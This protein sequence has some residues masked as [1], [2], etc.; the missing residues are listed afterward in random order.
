[1]APSVLSPTPANVP[2]LFSPGPRR[3]SSFAD[4]DTLSN[5]GMSH[6]FSLGRLS[7]KRMTSRTTNI[8]SVVE[9]LKRRNGDELGSSASSQFINGVSYASLLDW[10][11]GQRMSLLPPEGSPYDK[12][13]AWAQ[14]F[15][16]RIH[17][18]DLAIEPFAGDSFLAAE[19][20]YGYCNMLLELG[21][22]NAQALI[23]SF[24]FFY[25]TSMT[26]A[27]LLERAELF[28][29]TQEI[30]DQLVLAL[31]D[32]VTLVASVSSHFHKA[33][34]EM[35]RKRIHIDIYR[36]FPSQIQTFRQRC[37]KIAIAMWRHQL[38]R[39]NVDGDRVS[40]VQSIRSWLT[41]DD[42]VLNNIAESVSHLA[43]ERE[44]L[45]CLWMSSY[46]GRF[47]KSNL[48]ALSLA[49]KPGSGRT[50]LASVIVDHLQHPIGG[51]SYNALFIPINA[52][53]PA[54]TSARAVARTIL[55]QLFE[56][57][58][59]NVQL[60]QIL[61]DAFQRGK[62][63]TSEEE[64]DQILWTALG[65]ALGARLQGAKDLVLVVD[66]VD[67]ASCG[68][69]VLMQKLLTATLQGSNARLITLGSQRPASTEGLTCVQISDD[70]IFDD[71]SAVIRSHFKNQVLASMSDMEQETVVAR[72]AEAAN[73]SFLWAKLAVKRARIEGKPEGLRK[74]VDTLVE[75]KPTILDFVLD[76][77]QNPKV[78]AEAKHMLLWLAI[79]E[80]PLQMKELVLL[81]AVDVEK[82]T[83][84]E[85][86]IDVLGDQALGLLKSL[87][88]V[89]DGLVYLRHG[90]IRSAILEAFAK[91]KLVPNVK[92]PH[93][94]L[95]IRLLVYIKS[96]VTEQREPSLTSL[97]AH[98]TNILL[99]KHPLLDFALRYWPFHFRQTSVFV[100]G[101]RAKAAQE[102]TKYLPISTTVV[103]LQNT[104]WERL[105]TAVLLYY[106]MI[107]ANVCRETLTDN[108]VVT[109]QSIIF[110]AQL[111]RQLGR[112]AEAIPLFYQAAHTS[113]TLL[114]VKHTLT[115]HMASTFLELT[116]EHVTN[117]KVEIMMQRERCLTLLVECYKVHYGSTSENVVTV[118]KQLS[119]H[120]KLIKE[121]TKAQEIMKA[122]S[123]IT[124][125]EYEAHGTTG[126]LDVSLTA[127]TEVD[128]KT[129]DTFL[130]FSAEHDE[131]IE[132]HYDFEASLQLAQNYAAEG[133]YELAERT[134][135]EIW[136]RASEEHRMQATGLW[137]ERKME[138][139]LVYTQFLKS[140][141]RDR[142]VS[143]ILSSFWQDVQQKTTSIT[144][145]SSISYFQQIAQVMKTVG[146]S[147]AALSVYKYCSEYFQSTRR[148]ETSVYKEIQQHIETTHKEVLETVTTTTVTSESTLEELVFERFSSISTL[149]GT[150]FA[151]IENLVQMYISQHRWRDASRVIKRIL[152]VVWP[153]LFAPLLEDV[154]LPPKY[155][156]N[157][158]TLTG[159]LCQC[160]RSRRRT[161]K[162]QD[163]RVR[164]YRA[165]RFGKKVDDK[166]RQTVV[167]DL[168]RFLELTSQT[169]MIINVHQELL[170]DYVAH[171][172]EE[173]TIVIKELWTLARLTRPRPIFI[174]YYQQIIQKLNKGSATC[175]PEAFEPLVIVSTEL[176]N[177]GRYSD[178]LRH[179]VILF[180]TF[181]EQHKVSSKFEDHSF[182]QEVFNRYT[183]CLRATRTEFTTLHKVT[184]DY[185]A[186]C[187]TV[188]GMSASVTVQATYTLAKL[189]QESKRYESEAVALYE[190]LVKMKTT[191]I[192]LQEVSSIL[193][194]IYEEE[195]TLVTSTERR[196]SISSTQ[197]QRAVQVLKK[198]VT[199]VRQ[200]Y[201]WAH[202]E[203]LSKM[204][205]IVKLYVQA[206][207]TKT[208]VKELKEATVHILTS[209][210]SV[211]TLSRAAASIAS[212]YIAIGQTEKVT[213]L[214][215][216]IYRQ[217]IL[218]DTSNVEKVQFNLSSK[219]QHSLAFLA[220]L[221]HSLRY[222]VSSVTEILATLKTE[223]VY[224]EEFRMAVK[225]KS[226][227]LHS[228]TL[229][230]SRLYQFLV[231]NNRHT[232]ATHVFN[233]LK[234]YFLST[235]GKRIKCTE[236]AEVDI[237][238][239]TMLEYLT[240]HRSQNFVR[241]VGIVSNNRVVELLQAQK[242]DAACAL[243]LASFK[244]I[245]AQDNY[246]SPTIVKFVFTL[247]MTISG[248]DLAVRLPANKQLLKTSAIIMQ[249]AL[250]VI[251]ELKINLAQVD[252]DHLN[253]LIGLLG[254]QQDYQTM[255]WLL[256]M[257]WNSREVQRNWQPSLTLALGRRFIMVR[258]LVGDTT[259]A[260][261][262][263]EDV[264]Y[265]CRRVHGARH[266]STLEMS[267]LL[268][269]VYTGIAQRYQAHKDG[270]EL[271]KRY[272]KKSV[273]LHENILRAFSDPTTA[274]MEYMD[275]SMSLDGS[276]FELDLSD[277]GLL[278]GA[279]TP[280]EYVRNHLKLLKL[281]AE[282]LGDWPKD[283]SEYERLNA[284]L[285][286]EFPEDLKGVE[287]VE[288]W[289]LKAFG[290]GKA[291]SNEDQVDLQ[292][293]DWQLFDTQVETNGAE[294][295]EEEL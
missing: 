82:Q 67:E 131:V 238:L 99:S 42:Y 167:A 210:T 43:H 257:L 129:G 148:T 120:Y 267:V 179:Y 175:H 98:D 134:F 39:D 176:W 48:R 165:M 44:E 10:I 222:S 181:L 261:R 214:S 136:Q 106:R 173:H 58:I 240:T 114:T 70:L 60:F 164:V 190:E 265:N 4:S 249:D 126:H 153:S 228:V 24:G 36:T 125:T 122:I 274:D 157:S 29:V 172:G 273:A 194:A 251:Q 84:A 187:K 110:L 221:Q 280:G 27:N 169:D 197:Y 185:Q 202:E 127:P 291:E 37:E 259:G 284:D 242:L 77:L 183:Q 133:R 79:A 95:V 223:Y 208:A 132:S 117:S 278:A 160:Y 263:A 170:N 21:R 220:Q 162:E 231:K 88:F 97:N 159:R 143:S 248:R 270:K 66:G 239:Q 56:K 232:S 219:E 146:L 217:I 206:N 34:R 166:L 229:S 295:V 81:S 155:L 215:E 205:E 116:V 226:S 30:R 55:C 112:P 11:R 283:Y 83:V 111:Y 28:V 230:A 31:G 150:S 244:Y 163:T 186:K 59:G 293:K 8:T 241:S 212:S 207:E 107:I 252:I 139:I 247:G 102:F 33:V 74:V 13:L 245:S 277:S 294:T 86:E 85:K 198:R 18:F 6:S 200:T 260:L 258:Y 281:S 152:R 224:F 3:I 41:A 53:I 269:Q 92:D 193:E 140:Q 235:E 54:E 23:V 237:F 38:L 51:V 17:S 93:A 154:T 50:V 124:E 288:K 89:R 161:S 255:A 151:A 275:G 108:H 168:L 119:E 272:Y 75:K 103:L 137:E 264:V 227:T 254:E 9:S 236:S 68:E 121:E 22:E 142:E 234:N 40:E 253:S 285:F 171:Y 16:E 266:P 94:D 287:G 282:R 213:E 69:G 271:A 211:T 209:E 90:Q 91:G 15:I 80:R 109:L 14:L 178:A 199:T 19:L 191:A 62:L 147:T 182:V 203:S 218:K 276:A 72:I 243:A 20:A 100:N 71:I 292:F 25:S 35:N 144:S 204:E 76:A 64:Y 123:V 115:M 46:L 290:G 156:E 49:G 96:T 225:S 87:V 145:E 289:D 52:R 73:S 174:D 233:G 7:S 196:E 268:S 105:P 279:L 141:K 26:L 262:L 216:E 130:L 189:C 5:A 201:G 177:Q 2:R 250:R 138:A 180:Q 101:G 47:L 45:T 286:R 184:V 135:V 63:C 12:V 256:T 61:T 192:D 118:L 158:V 246:R 104:V 149:D 188:F 32:L 78:T 128:T 65:E 113:S 1:M 195:T 57:R